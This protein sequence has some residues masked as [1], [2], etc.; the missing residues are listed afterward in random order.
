MLGIA[1]QLLGMLDLV[2]AVT[3]GVLSS[4]PPVG[5]L[6]HGISDEHAAAENLPTFAVPLL[7]TL[8]IIS[9]AQAVSRRAYVG[10]QANPARPQVQ[11][12]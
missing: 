3:L 11:F 4:P 6:G 7:L 5:I 9:I 1:R 12:G 2:T 8:H 10:T